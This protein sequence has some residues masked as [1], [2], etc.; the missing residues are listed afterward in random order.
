MIEETLRTALAEQYKTTAEKQL[1]NAFISTVEST[2][3]ASVSQ[4]PMM[5][6]AFLS[7]AYSQDTGIP[8]EQFTAYLSA[9][10]AEELE[11]KVRA[12][13]KKQGEEAYLEGSAFRTFCAEA[14]LARIDAATDED[15]A[16]LYD[17]FMPST[18]SS[19]T[20][21]DNLKALGLD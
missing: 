19:S 17:G 2:V 5:Q 1:K 13:A 18:V 12:E 4:S 8:A 15:A 9:L 6:I 14:L 10:T 11:A 16:A 21:A 20:L 3:W 7:A